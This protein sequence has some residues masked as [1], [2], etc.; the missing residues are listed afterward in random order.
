MILALAL[1]II[2]YVGLFYVRN[3]IQFYI[4]HLTYGLISTLAAIVV[5]PLSLLRPFDLRNVRYD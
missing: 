5:I 1:F 2:I 3:P 4:K